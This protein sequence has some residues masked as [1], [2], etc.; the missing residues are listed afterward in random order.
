MIRTALLVVSTIFACPALDNP[1]QAGR[2]N[3]VLSIGDQAPVWTDL[4]GTD[5]VNHSLAEL[6][7]KDVVVVAITCNSCPYANDVEPRLIELQKQYSETGVAIV[8]ISASK[9]ESDRLPAMKERASEQGYNFAYLHDETQQTA[10]DFGAKYTP[11]FYV[12]DKARR[13]VYMGAFSNSSFG[14]EATKQYVTQAIDAVLAG[15]KPKVTETAPIGCAV[16][17]DRVR[18]SRK[19][20]TP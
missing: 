20:T 19:V 17:Y 5:G 16:R 7:N 2:Y 18:R 6:Q 8:A 3:K 11:E 13:V 1:A 12:L 14:K 9:S 4:P 10:R 15:T